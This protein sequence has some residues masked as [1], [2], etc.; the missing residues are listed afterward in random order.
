MD[1]I[2]YRSQRVQ[3]KNLTGNVSKVI[4]GIYQLIVALAAVDALFAPIKNY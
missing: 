3:L 2:P 1:G 4:Y